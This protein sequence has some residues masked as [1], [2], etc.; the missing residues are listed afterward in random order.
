[1]NFLL[2]DTTSAHIL[3]IGCSRL[4][5][6]ECDSLLKLGLGKDYYKFTATM[7]L[8]APSPQVPIF[9]N[10][11]NYKHVIL[12]V[13]GKAQENYVALEKEKSIRKSARPSNNK[14]DLTETVIN[15]IK[16]M[17]GLDLSFRRRF[18]S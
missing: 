1:M 6:K 10:T 17:T 15:W 11:D 3:G 16:K 4:H 9:G 7:K 12:K 8:E 5:C 18:N 2:S 13:S 14:Y